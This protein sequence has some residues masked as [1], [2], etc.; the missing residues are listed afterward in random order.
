MNYICPVK[1]EEKNLTSDENKII[2]TRNSFGAG[3]NI[4][5]GMLNDLSKV[6]FTMLF[7]DVDEIIENIF[8]DNNIEYEIKEIPSGEKVGAF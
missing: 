8:K 7:G 6:E 4:R 5:D 1:V 3:L 2:F